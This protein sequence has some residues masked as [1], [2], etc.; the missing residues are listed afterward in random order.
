MK[1]ALTPTSVD[2]GIH[3]APKPDC[4]SA[5]SDHSGAHKLMELLLC[6]CQRQLKVSAMLTLSDGGFSLPW[7][8]KRRTTMEESGVKIGC[9][10]LMFC[11]ESKEIK[12]F[13]I[14]KPLLLLKSKNENTAH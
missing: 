2:T 13:E 12:H 3:F 9:K 10:Y 8:E 11:L 14:S 7:G 5:S 4:P 1:K 6:D